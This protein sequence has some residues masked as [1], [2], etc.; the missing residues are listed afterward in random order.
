MKMIRHYVVYDPDY[1]WQTVPLE[2]WTS[3]YHL[4]CLDPADFSGWKFA[5]YD[6]MIKACPT[7]RSDPPPSPTSDT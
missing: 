5:H 2:A 3:C 1:G 4:A 7:T 6:V